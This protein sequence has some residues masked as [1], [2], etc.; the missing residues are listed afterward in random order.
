MAWALQRA[1]HGE[2]PYW[3]AIALAAMLGQI[4]LRGGG[5][6]FGHGSMNGVGNPRIDVPSPEFT[7][8]PNPAGRAIPVARLTDMLE[9]PGAPFHFNGRQDT[10]PDIDL[11]Y[12]AGGNPFHHHQD[13]NRLTRAWHKPA[14]V[15]VHESWW[16]PT[17]R[18][19][20]IVLPATTPLERNDIGGS[21]RD[22]FIF[23]MQQAI[24]PVGGSRDDFDIFREL[25]ARGGHEPAFS[26]GRDTEA[27]LRELWRRV[28]TSAADGGV[29]LPAYE[30]F[31]ARGWVELPAPVRDYVMF[32][33]FRADPLAHPLRT[34]SGRIELVSPTIR[35]FGYVDCPAHPTWLPPVE[36]LGA[37]AVSRFPLHLITIQPPDRL[38][39]QMDPGPVSQ[40]RKVAGRERIA[41]NP[42][43]AQARGLSNGDLA[44]VFN[45]RGAC[46][47]GVAL[48]AGLMSGVV[49]MATGAWFD[50]ASDGLERGG[51]PNVLSLDIGTSSLT[52]GPSALSVL[53]E[54]ARWIGTAPEVQ[55]YRVPR[56]ESA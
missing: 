25:A 42:A 16:T 37:A 24:A 22:P 7:T 40:A 52:Q 18:R 3:M 44:H 34:P 19:A 12:W 2:Q 21:S 43:D 23:A 56:I 15:V 39:S 4:G 45:N 11:I 6:A 54:V 41:I 28:C 27:W 46:L 8:G 10:Y 50:P 53:V 30:E 14:T 5:F 49:V 51:N 29:A 17:A 33:A 26:E 31:L 9:K 35:S 1:H 36:W 20:D 38:H 55:A 32:D 47:A 13:L 48:D